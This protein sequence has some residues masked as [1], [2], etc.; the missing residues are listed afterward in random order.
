[1]TG[2][3]QPLSAAQ[4]QQHPHA[5]AA[6]ASLSAG[7]TPA[8]AATAAASRMWAR[9]HTLST[10]LLHDSIPCLKRTKRP[11]ASDSGDDHQ[12]PQQQKP[13]GAVSGKKGSASA[14]HHRQQ[15]GCQMD[16]C[17]PAHY[18]NAVDVAACVNVLYGTLLKL[19]SLGAKVPTFRARVAMTTRLMQLSTLAPAEQHRFLLQHSSLVRL[20]FMEY[21]LNALEDWL[22]C[23][24]ELLLQT[25]PAMDM[26]FRI[27]GSMCD[28]FRYTQ[29][30]VCIQF[31]RL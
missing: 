18:N 24:R 25:C 14:A 8:E 16:F 22:P 9:A 30:P 10:M 20:C 19:Y 7:G 26:Y 17:H 27:A 5:A 3:C 21:S 15:Q 6:V 29:F 12:Q 2:G 28:I 13:P 1:M 4:Q 11:A 23:E 31:N